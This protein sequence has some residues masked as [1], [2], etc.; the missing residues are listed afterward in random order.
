[1]DKQSPI[2]EKIILFNSLFRGRVDVY[3]LRWYS[4]KTNKSGY[5]PVC[6]NRGSPECNFKCNSCRNRNFVQLSDNAVCNHLTDNDE[7][8][9][10]VIGIYPMLSDEKTYLL[11]IDF[12]GDN[13]RDDVNAVRDVC[14]EYDIFA[15]VERSRSGNGAHLWIFF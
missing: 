15:A 8:C 13:W 4:T 9:R 7:F 6:R 10:N 1:M 11:V 3:A 5:S 14:K 2:E 12:S